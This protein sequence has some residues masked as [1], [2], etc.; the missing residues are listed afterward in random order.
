MMPI[1]N[2]PGVVMRREMTTQVKFFDLN[3]DV[4]SDYDF[5]L[6]AHIL[7]WKGK[8]IPNLFSYFSKGGNSTTKELKG[9][10][11]VFRIACRHAGF[12][13]GAFLALARNVT[14]YFGKYCISKLPSSYEDRV[15]QLYH[16]WRS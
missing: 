6:R 12:S 14:R 16:K 13:L 5:I 8:Y 7:G 3:I 10:F 2:F 9:H 1:I 11:E 15:Y 4:P